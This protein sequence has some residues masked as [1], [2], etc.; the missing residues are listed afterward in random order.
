M[1]VVGGGFAGLGCARKLAKHRDVRVTLLDRNN[2]HQ[3]QPLLYQVATSQLGSS[4]I[5]FSLR[6]L[7]RNHPNVDVKLAEVASIDPA[8]GTVTAD[9]RRDLDRRRG[10][11][12]G[13][14]AAELLRHA[15]ARTQRLPALLAATTRSGCARASSRVFED[16]DRDPS[17]LDGARSTSSSSAAAPTGV[18]MAGALADMIDQTMTVEYHDLAVTAARMHLVDL[19]HTL[20]GPFSD[21]RARLR[22]EGPA[23]QGRR[24]APRHDGHRGRARAR[25]ARRRHR[26]PDAVRGVGRR[27][28][29]ARA[30]RRGRRCRRGAAGASTCSPT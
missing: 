27:H 11:A 15:R 2:Y 1:I 21:A 14:L 3:F 9:G 17:L 8:A 6:K 23:A 28:H 13:R 7:F 5:A 30:G 12:G 16:A 10:R 26:D 25:D 20:L 22:R 29:G 19:G 18:E 4:D 24:A